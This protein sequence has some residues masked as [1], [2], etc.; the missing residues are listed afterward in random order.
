MRLEAGTALFVVSFMLAGPASADTETS[1]FLN[2]EPGDYI[3]AGL[4]R[5]CRCHY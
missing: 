5:L 1:L 3:G 4:Q 2:S